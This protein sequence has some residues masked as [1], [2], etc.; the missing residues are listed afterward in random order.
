MPLYIVFG[1]QMR[2]LHGC[3][4]LSGIVRKKRG[5][6]PDSGPKQRSFEP[7]LAV[8]CGEG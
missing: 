1:R 8:T 4:M 6:I 5:L 2:P 7:W 3:L